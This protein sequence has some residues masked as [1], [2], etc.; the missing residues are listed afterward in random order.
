MK[1]FHCGGAVPC[2]CK[3]AVAAGWG[4]T[5][6]LENELADMAAPSAGRPK[7]SG[8]AGVAGKETGVKGA[9]GGGGE[10]K[11][12]RFAAGAALDGSAI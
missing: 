6:E 5:K 4:M 11:T 1:G 7:P 3:A 12:P 10:L 9:A 8:N 2:G